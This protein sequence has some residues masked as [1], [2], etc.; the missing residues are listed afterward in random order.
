M[1][2]KRETRH[3]GDAA[4]GSAADEKNASA[5]HK[6]RVPGAHK[7]EAPASHAEGVPVGRV[8]AV[9]VRMYRQGLGDCHLIT[10]DEGGEPEEILFKDPHLVASIVLFVIA[11]AFAMSGMPLPLIE[12]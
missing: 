3:S 4:K 5:G 9:R 2:K 6:G 10:F 8:P 1:G 12:K 11:A 7:E